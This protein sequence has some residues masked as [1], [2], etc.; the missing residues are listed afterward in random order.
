MF[1]H[2]KTRV[3]LLFSLPLNGQ[4]HLVMAAG[5]AKDRDAMAEWMRQHIAGYYVFG[6]IHIA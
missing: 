6:F 1:Q 2:D 3:E 5:A 4:G